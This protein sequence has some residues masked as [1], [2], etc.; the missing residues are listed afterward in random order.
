MTFVFMGVKF[1]GALSTPQLELKMNEKI[2]TY[3]SGEDQD[4]VRN[5]DNLQKLV[6]G[7]PYNDYLYYIVLYL[8]KY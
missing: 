1:T 2:N 3:H 6:M 5:W 7:Q 4:S 8:T